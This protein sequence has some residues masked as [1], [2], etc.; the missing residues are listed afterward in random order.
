[1]WLEIAFLNLDATKTKGSLEKTSRQEN[2]P[3]V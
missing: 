1:M 2:K 3:R